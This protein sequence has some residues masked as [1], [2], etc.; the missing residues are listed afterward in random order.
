MAKS[1]SSRHNNSRLVH[2]PGG[3]QTTNAQLATHHRLR[4]KYPRRD[5]LSV[6]QSSV[7][8]QRPLKSLKPHTLGAFIPVLSSPKAENGTHTKQDT[9]TK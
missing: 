3:V 1:V 7:D 2:P 4:G 5:N 6:R 9:D 8:R